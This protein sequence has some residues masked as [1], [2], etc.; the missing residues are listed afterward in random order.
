[1]LARLGG[2]L[3]IAA[4][5]LACLAGW[6]AL[7]GGVVGL[8]LRNS[9]PP[10]PGEWVVAATIA[11][12]GVGAVAV[13]IGGARPFE[14]PARAGFAVLGLGSLSLAS[15]SVLPFAGI[16]V[17]SIAILLLLVGG[18]V[19]SALGWL[20]VGAALA[21]VPGRQ[22]VVGIVLLTGFLGPVL[23]VG[24]GPSVITGPLFLLLPI[25]LAGAGVLIFRTGSSDRG[26]RAT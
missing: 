6:I 14:D 21:G 10:A 4:A 3:L 20:L 11:M 24:N 19:M 17:D 15:A 23:T 13:S 2:S 5:G 12:L 25:G 16:L 1:M 22:R 7:S 9:P 8:A 18:L 26:L